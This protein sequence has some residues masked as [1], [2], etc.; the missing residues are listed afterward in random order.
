MKFKSSYSNAS[1][2]RS[3][4]KFAFYGD[5]NRAISILYFKLDEIPPA[6]WT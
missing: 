4:Y 3:A 5:I 1:N 2:L 6:T